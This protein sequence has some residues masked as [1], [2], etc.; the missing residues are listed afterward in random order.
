MRLLVFP[1]T[2]SSLLRGNNLSTHTMHRPDFPAAQC[3]HS[4]DFILSNVFEVEMVRRML[5]GC[6]KRRFFSLLALLFAGRQRGL[7]G[8]QT[9]FYSQEVCLVSN[10]MMKTTVLKTQPLFLFLAFCF[11][12]TLFY[13]CGCFVCINAYAPQMPIE[14]RRGHQIY[15]GLKLWICELLCGCLELNP[16]LLEKQ[17]S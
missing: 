17:S 9:G 3:G 14:A 6:L 4:C 13:M 1:K 2:H 5:I 8:D 15:L 12:F 7:F 11:V 16:D 10:T